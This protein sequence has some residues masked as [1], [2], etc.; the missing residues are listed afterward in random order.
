[1]AAAP[2]REY[3]LCFITHGSTVLLLNR[4]KAP[5]M[6]CW[7]GVGGK[8]EPGET[9]LACAHREVEEETYDYTPDTY[10]VRATGRMR[11]TVSG[12]HVGTCHMFLLELHAP[13]PASR[14]Y[15][16]LTAEGVLL[17]H[18]VTWVLHP[19]NTGVV[20]NLRVL[21]PALM[22]AAP[23]APVDFVCDYDDAG[24]ALSTTRLA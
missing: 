1:M 2:P 9:P 23:T 18:P 8:M 7:N 13:P 16:L 19:D 10:A 5:W 11:W 22:D 6:G 14:T 4:L 24:N 15:P 12:T 21:I 20:A 3:T 17:F